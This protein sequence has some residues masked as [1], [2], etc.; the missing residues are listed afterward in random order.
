M[1]EI[2][3]LARE[4]KGKTL[5]VEVMGKYK[6]TDKCLLESCLLIHKPQIIMLCRVWVGLNL[7][8]SMD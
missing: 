2:S 4:G 3:Q 6:D 5:K 1:K 8:W 7:N